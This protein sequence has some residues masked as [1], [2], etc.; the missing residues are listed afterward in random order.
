[1]KTIDLRGM[2]LAGCAALAVMG[3]ATA[4]QAQPVRQYAIQRQD[5]ASALRAYSLKSGQDVIYDPGLVRGRTSPGASGRLTDD[6]ALEAVS[7]THLTL[8]TILLV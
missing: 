6:A 7:Y 5:L 3:V 4:A 2:L 1:M 8:P